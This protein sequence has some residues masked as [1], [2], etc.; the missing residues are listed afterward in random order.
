M[1]QAVTLEQVQLAFTEAR[2]RG[3]E[4]R[5]WIV[6][7]PQF[8]LELAH[9]EFALRP[10]SESDGPTSEDLEQAER[11][12]RRATE[13][14]LQSP[15]ANPSGPGITARAAALSIDR[16]QLAKT[17]RLSSSFLYR[18]DK[19]FV[20]VESLPRRLRQDLLR[21]LHW[22]AAASSRVLVSVG[23]AAPAHFSAKSK[24]QSSGQQTFQEAL[25]VDHAI[26]PEDR[27]WWI[28]LMEHEALGA[29]R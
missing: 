15:L 28:A 25:E 5:D 26:S 1:A 16:Q 17:L 2:E 7:Y 8:A 6:R 13:E 12:M 29:G 14:F 21:L 27:A 19:G 22:P 20:A 4:L 23:S 18:I 3:E 11:A 10:I 9:L 24:P